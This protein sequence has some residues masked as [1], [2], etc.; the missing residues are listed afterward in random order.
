MNDLAHALSAETIKMKRTLALWLA[1]LTPAALVFLEVAAV[2]QSQGRLSSL[3]PDLNRWS[4]LF[5]DLFNIWVILIFP[6]FITL[7]TALLGQVEHANHTWKLVHTQ[8]IP[9]WAT[10]AAKQI[11]GLG[12]V[13]LGMLALIGLTLIGG[14][15]LDI[16]MPELAFALPI[17]W[18]EMLIQIG[19]ALL[20][21]GIILAI[22]TWI[23]L[24]A[25]SFVVASAIGIGMTIAGLVLMSLEWT[26]FFPWT[27]PGIA[28]NHYYDGMDFSVYLVMGVVGGLAISLVGNWYIGSQEIR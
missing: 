17:P 15:I 1:L 16:L 25:R 26:E 14:T 21:G 22:H 9:R 8:P 6:L 7:E 3:S 5:E 19:I 4:L 23:G 2:T 27:I 10:L 18:K 11:W 13:A 24:Q 12:L 20:A 28:L